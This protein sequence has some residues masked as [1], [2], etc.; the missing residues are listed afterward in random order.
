MWMPKP[1]SEGQLS[2]RRDAEYCGT[3]SG[4]RHAKPRL[5]PSANVLNEELL[6][7]GEPLRLEPGGVLM[8]SQRLSVQPMYTDDQCGRYVGL[9]EQ[10]APLRDFLTVAGEDDCF[11]RVRWNVYR[12]LPSTV[13]LERLSDKLSRDCVGGLGGR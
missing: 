3:F 12:D 11:G 2:P 1:K 4:Q 9:F 5:R 10:H 13:V 6:V 7:C 8:E